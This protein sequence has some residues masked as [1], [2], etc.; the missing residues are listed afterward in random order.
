MTL[1]DPAMLEGSYE[2]LFDRGMD[3]ITAENFDGAEP[4][5]QRLRNRLEK[6]SEKAFRLRPELKE[7][8]RS[9]LLALGTIQAR[10]GN[11][12]EA[13]ALYEQSLACLDAESNPKAIVTTKRF[14]IEAKQYLEGPEAV[15]DELRALVVLEPSLAWPCLR[16]GNVLLDM[17]EEEEAEAALKQAIQRNTERNVDLLLAHTLLFNLYERQNRLQE[18]EDLWRS[19]MEDVKDERRDFQPVYSMYLRHGELEKAEYWLEKEEQSTLQ[20]E[21]YWGK[22]AQAR[23]DHEAAIRHWKLATAQS[24]DFDSNEPLSWAFAA[25]RVK[26][27]PK[28]I[29][30]CLRALEL[31]GDAEWREEFL[32][33]LAYLA[34]GRL[35]AAHRAFQK[36]VELSA[37]F[38]ETARERFLRDNGALFEEYLADETLKAEFAPYLEQIAAPAA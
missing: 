12:Q 14:I 8:L 5:F 18:A 33:G 11:W 28:R 13:L 15:V 7:L 4:V 17:G 35:E 10:R 22:I 23:G 1:I 20:K 21:F 9:A 6:L 3:L 36:G 2:D 30:S 29:I 24:P 37:K 19:L 16:L 38:S 27:N 34:D 25:L 32:L 31:E 26:H